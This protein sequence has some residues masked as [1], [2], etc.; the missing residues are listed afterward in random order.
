MKAR[1]I[2][3][4]SSV[5]RDLA[6][7]KLA[8]LLKAMNPVDLPLGLTEHQRHAVSRFLEGDVGLEQAFDGVFIAVARIL[9]ATRDPGL[10][11]RELVAV[12]ARILQGK[13]MNEVSEILGSTLEEAEEL[14]GEALR[15]M[16]REYRD[17][18]G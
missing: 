10:G 15:R 5:Y 3:A 11:E 6:A 12:V 17:L 9:A 7:E 4:A 13:P 8:M 14:V 1:L 16:L 18:W 2:L